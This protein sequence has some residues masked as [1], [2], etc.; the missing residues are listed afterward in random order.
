MARGSHGKKGD[1]M[2]SANLVRRTSEGLTDS[3]PHVGYLGAACWAMWVMLM[4]GGGLLSLTFE[5]ASILVRAYVLSSV[6]L[7]LTSASVALAGSRACKVL[8]DARAMACFGVAASAGTLCAIGGAA[9]SIP[10]VFYVGSALTGVGTGVIALRC[11]MQFSQ[12]PPRSSLI[13][14]ALMMACALVACAL[15]ITLPGEALAAVMVLLPLFATAFS[16]IVPRRESG[17]S[18]ESSA[19][20]MFSLKDMTLAFAIFLLVLLVFLSSGVVPFAL[21][22]EVFSV[23]STSCVLMA[24]S[25]MAVIVIVAAL[26]PEGFRFERIYCAV[27]VALLVFYLVVAVGAVRSPHLTLFFSTASITLNVIVWGFFSCLSH[28]AGRLALPLFA[29]GRAVVTLG[30]SVGWLIGSYELLSIAL[31]F[32]LVLGAGL[33]AFALVVLFL[34]LRC[35]GSL[36]RV[37]VLD[38]FEAATLLGCEPASA[39]G[40]DAAFEGAAAQVEAAAREGGAAREG[41]FGHEGGAVCEEAAACEGIAA[42]EGAAVSSDPAASDAAGGAVGGAVG[43]AAGLPSAAVAESVPLRPRWRLRMLLLAEEYDLTKREAEVFVLMAKGKDAQSMAEELCVS[44]STVRTHV[45]NIYTKCDVHSRHEFQ[46]FV[47]E[48]SCASQ[49]IS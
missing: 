42:R 12:L 17:C 47:E 5:D 21:H 29:V 2:A 35:S 28:A 43:G 33:V 18:L 31:D 15:F 11:A 4:Y 44:L 46:K 3:V 19:Q 27:L 36:R 41:I 38:D 23:R 14:A 16:F 49:D 26:V 39:P 8:D 25:I 45:R 34:V 37:P 22:Y 6:F 9:A 10:L 13:I 32:L 30:V 20:R 24:L 40:E 1:R 7:A 48:K